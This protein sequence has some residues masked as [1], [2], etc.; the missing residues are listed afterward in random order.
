[1]QL[2]HRPKEYERD[3]EDYQFSR[4]WPPFFVSALI[5]F[6]GGPG[7]LMQRNVKDSAIAINY[8]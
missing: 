6:R 8:A 3:A 2:I 5:V 1:V 7:I 4:R